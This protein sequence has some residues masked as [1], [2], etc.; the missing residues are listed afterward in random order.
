MKDTK[1]KSLS[2]KIDSNSKLGKKSKE[3]WKV[4]V[5]VIAAVLLIGIDLWFILKVF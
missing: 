3:F 1:V 4:I 5:L 2:G